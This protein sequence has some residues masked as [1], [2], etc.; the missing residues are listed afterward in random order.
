ANPVVHFWSL[1][2]EEQF[3][4]CWPLL[5][6]GGYLVTRRAGARQWKVLRLIIAAGFLLSL[7]AALHLSTV[8]LSRAYYGTDTRAYELL[9]GA[10]L[11][12]TPAV[13]RLARR[14]RGAVRAVA[15]LNVAVLVGV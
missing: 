13:M 14:W 7:V 10:L 15:P 3:Y 2:V 12:I 1:A 6:S 5:L 11:A 9:A 4:L 8:N